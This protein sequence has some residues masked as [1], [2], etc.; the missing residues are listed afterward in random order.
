LYLFSVFAS[1]DV[2]D[3]FAATNS[4][5]ISDSKMVGAYLPKSSYEVRCQ[6]PVAFEVITPFKRKDFISSPLTPP[7]RLPYVP[8][9]SIDIV[10]AFH[11]VGKNCQ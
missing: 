10:L 5:G 9:P 11:R 2:K 3:S 4:L 8:E 7:R 6:L 1:L